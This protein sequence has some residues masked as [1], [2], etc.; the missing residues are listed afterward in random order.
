M[1]TPSLGVTRA[2]GVFEAGAGQ[3]VPEDLVP[4]VR[5]VI[6]HLEGGDTRAREAFVGAFL[7]IW[8]EGEAGG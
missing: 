5:N 3:V 7:R 1:T 2:G 8:R 4:V 6:A